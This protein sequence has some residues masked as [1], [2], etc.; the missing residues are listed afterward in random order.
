MDTH[1]SR[2]SSPVSRYW[3][4]VLLFLAAAGFLAWTEHRAHLFGALPYLIVLLCPIIHLFAHR[5]HNH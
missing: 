1:N 3:G 4:A 2:G 5:R